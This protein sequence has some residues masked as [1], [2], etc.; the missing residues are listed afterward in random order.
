MKR[1]VIALNN[2]ITLI[3]TPFDQKMALSQSIWSGV[4]VLLL[5]LLLFSK[6]HIAFNYEIN[7]DEFYYL[8]FIFKHLR[9]ELSSSLQTFHVH[10]FSWMSLLTFNE[11]NLVV[12]GRI[13]MVLLQVLTG[14]FLYSICRNFLTVTASLFAI[15]SYFSFSYILLMG[16]SFRTDPIATFCVTAIVSILLNFQKK[17]YLILTSA[18]L[19]SISLLVT[20]KSVLYLPT[21]ILLGLRRIL[22]S[23][24]R[25]EDLM[26]VAKIL[27]STLVFFLIGLFFHKQGV[28]SPIKQAEV[29][30]LT[31]S[32]S[33]TIEQAEFFP[34]KAYF[35][36]TLVFDVVFWGTLCSGCVLFWTIDKQKFIS[37]P[38]LLNFKFISWVM[39]YV[40][41]LLPL[42]SILFYRNAFP[43]FYTFALPLAS[44]FCGLVWFCLFDKF[45][46]KAKHFIA[47]TFI[48]LLVLNTVKM[49][50]ERPQTRSNNSQKLLV[51]EIHKIFPKPVSYFDRC[52]MVSTFR[53]VGFFMSSWGMENYKANLTPTFEQII[54]K[55]QP[56]FYIANIGYLEEKTLKVELD[57]SIDLSE[58]DKNVIG[59]NYIHHWNKIYVAGKQFNFGH[60]SSELNFHIQISGVYTLEAGSKVNINKTPIYPGET[61]FLSEGRHQIS[62]KDGSGIVKLRWGDNLYVPSNEVQIE[63]VFSGF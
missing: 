30:L 58:T 14:A 19:G 25:K 26:Y 24:E 34:G 32:F 2:Y 49:A 53:Q 43:Y 48:V 33:K 51:N 39:L 20:I 55:S 59:R 62:A 3:K 22:L 27:I 31:H 63:N 44:F 16:A 15:F 29:S 46:S 5:L 35:L 7:W 54:I 1:A 56:V 60:S 17:N 37:E 11:V 40:A 38:A 12:V 10:L 57:N 21:F 13:V 6:I 18:L 41:F 45:E 47:G 61:L 28:E 36:N 8:S 52:S 4:L 9:G 42:F 23:N 50:V